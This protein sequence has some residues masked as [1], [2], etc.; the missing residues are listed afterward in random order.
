[1]IWWCRSWEE[2]S[3][4]NAD[5]WHEAPSWQEED[6]EEE[7]PAWKKLKAG[8]WADWGAAW[9]D[10]AWWGESETP[11]WSGSASSD[12]WLEGRQWVD[13][14]YDAGP[15]MSW[16]VHESWEKVEA[17]AAPSSSSW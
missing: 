7:E 5:S 8:K 14:T 11:K 16:V 3:H 2:A 9:D 12:A 10:E 6:E 15:G 4:W 17:K 1:L 13:T